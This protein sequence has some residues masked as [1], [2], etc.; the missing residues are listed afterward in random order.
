MNRGSHKIQGTTMKIYLSSLPT[1]VLNMIRERAPHRKPNVLVT[2][3]GLK[4]PADYT[5]RNREKIGSLILDCGAFSLFNKGLRGE[6]LDLAADKLFRGFKAHITYANQ[7]YDFIFSMDDKFD[8]ESFEHNLNRLH[9]LEDA[10]LCVLP[11]AHNLA[12]KEIPYYVSQNY[13]CIAIGQCQGVNREDLEIINPV[14]ESLYWE[15][16]VKVHMFGMTTPNV[17]LHIPAYSCDSK[18]WLDYAI[19]GCVLYWNPENANLDKT[20][21][22]YLSKYGIVKDKA[23]GV[24][25]RKYIHLENFKQ[26]VLTKYGI[27]WSDLMGNKRQEYR[28][29]VNSLYFLELEEMITAYHKTIGIIFP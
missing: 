20:D 3:Y 11:V 14:V 1:K 24:D 17:M 2:Y 9:V 7:L 18:T 5:M 26:H 28:A 23:L 29:L 4:D 6:E 8:P 16:R 22:I 27:T 10:G 12:S 25:Y 19:R 15:N 21:T 13:P